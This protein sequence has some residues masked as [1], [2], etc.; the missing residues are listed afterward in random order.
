MSDDDQP[1]HEFPGLIDD[2]AVERLR[3]ARALVDEQITAYMAAV[4]EAYGMNRIP[5]AWIAVIGSTELDW[6]H[7]QE[8]LIT[9]HPNV[10]YSTRVG[11][12]SSALHDQ[13]G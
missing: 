1:E 2:A 7:G 3:A 5:T 10:P 6:R 12:L 9:L 4:N 13:L 8:T 11:L